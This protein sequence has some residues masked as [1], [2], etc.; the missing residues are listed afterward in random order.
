MTE[1]A[2]QAA[3]SLKLAVVIPVRNGAAFIG[4][5]IDSLQPQ[6][7]AGIGSCEVI[8]VDDASSDGTA[9]IL[10]A[11]PWV[12]LL[13]HPV[14]KGAGAA[15]NTGA[16]AA[17]ADLLVFLDADTRVRETDF[18]AR[19][20]ALMR[21][22][23]DCAAFSGCY[24]DENPVQ[25]LFSLYLD[26]A[27]ATMREAILDRAAASSLNG[28]VCGVRKAAFEAMGG[29]SEDPRVTLEDVDLGF[30]L[31]QAGYRHWFSGTLRVEHRQPDLRHYTTELVSRTRHYLHLIRR[32][33]QFSDVMGGRREGFARTGFLLGVAFLAGGVVA[34][35]AAGLG[36][37]LLAAS[38]W[39]ARRFLARLWQTMP[40]AALPVALVFHLVTSL[41]L[42][43]G[44]LRGIMDTM[45][46]VARRTL[47]DISMV[48]AYLRSLMTRGAGGY[49]I[50]FLTHRCNAH[51]GHCFDHPQRQ[52]I[53]LTDELDLPRIRRLAASTGPLG[54][55]SLTG[56]EPLLRDDIAEIAA[57]YYAA[58]VRSF[59]VTSNGSYPERLARLLPQLASAAPRARIII[60]TSL[61]GLGAEH[62]R[63]RGLP[64]LYRKVE[65]SLAVLAEA[66]Q[67]LP[68]LRMHIC[69]TLT[70]ANKHRL[71]PT[72]AALREFHP[73]QIELNRLR[74]AP[75]DP[76]LRGIDDAGYDA[77]CALLGAAHGLPR[78]RS[79]LTQLLAALDRTM[80][81]IV[82][83]PNRPWPCGTCLAGRRLA[84][85]HADG[86]VLPCEMI[87]TVRPQHAAS[88]DGFVL[89]RLG[90]HGDNLGALL[91]SPQARRVTDYIAATDCRC[92]FECAIL[93]TV[94]YR[95]WRL[96][97]FFAPAIKRATGNA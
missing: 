42:V 69:L 51:C 31:G 53:G 72:L 8:V 26:A 54:H 89:G 85:I 60:K 19:C 29:F 45:H 97:R 17:K 23:P 4:T 57:A 47:I 30:R 83:Q 58:G 22:Q 41:G 87:R 2:D 11:Y 3:R 73:D 27:E 36:A 71:E 49:L 28:C 78:R 43:A 14:R 82:R 21:E 95:P 86:A 46:F 84:V 18:L 6:D 38:A 63:L 70:E 39:R 76:N 16:R 94:S 20:A 10:A 40:P 34:P 79:G 92:S 37:I 93:A 74:G 32:Y 35:A 75:T 55:V 7:L 15:R 96:W 12:R 64:G 81:L 67:W 48:L 62:D 65:H 68:Q 61:D 88:R 9:A 52:R 25:G 13:A 90:A 1:P 24:Y 66:R 59:S 50:H 44:S 77:A 33:R 80:S 5:L 91:A 56:G